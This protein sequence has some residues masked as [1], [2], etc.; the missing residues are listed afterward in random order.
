MGTGTHPYGGN[1]YNAVDV[2]GHDLYGIDV[3]PGIMRWDLG[4]YSV[5]H[6]PGVAVDHF[7]VVYMP[8]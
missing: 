5:D 1:A 2:I 4:P 6:L 3:Y 7:A 8:E